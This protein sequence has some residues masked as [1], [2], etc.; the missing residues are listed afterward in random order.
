MPQAKPTQVI[1]HRIELQQTERET[2][3]NYIE[4]QQKQKWI[5]TAGQVALPVAVGGAIV[6]G[7]YIG[8]L[9]WREIN[10]ALVALDP[11]EKFDEFKQNVTGSWPFKIL[12]GLNELTDAV[13]LDV[14]D[15][16]N[17]GPVAGGSK[18][19]RAFTRWVFDLL[20]IGDDD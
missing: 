11:S 13:F 19:G 6:G 15:P 2:L 7:A 1:V 5:Q 4:V 16:L 8:T 20:G 12:G 17:T 10:E 9:A 14:N 3:K 18:A